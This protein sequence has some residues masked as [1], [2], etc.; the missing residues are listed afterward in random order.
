MSDVYHA[1]IIDW[2][3]PDMNGIEV[4]R[5]I[6]SLNDDT[7]IIILTAYD[8]ADIEEE[9]RAAG[10]TAFCEKPLFLSELRKVLAEPFRVQPEQ[11]TALQPKADFSGKHLLLVEDNALNREIAIEILKEAGFLVDTA[12]DGVEAVEKMEQSVPGQYDLILMD[13]QM[14]RMDGYEATAEIR[15]QSADVP[16]IAVTA[17]AFASDEQKVLSSGF[18]GYMPKPINARQ[19]KTQVL[20]MLRK[21]MTLI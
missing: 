13:I 9:A 18:D 10:V 3:L 4:T 7:P 17:F 8:W 14:P 15:K 1:Y 19:L 21:R 5:Q 12:G 16:I 6:R 2:R 11:T 20:D